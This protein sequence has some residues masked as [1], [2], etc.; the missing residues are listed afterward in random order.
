MQSGIYSKLRFGTI[1]REGARL[2]NFQNLPYVDDVDIL[3]VIK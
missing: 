2:G 3:D 1:G